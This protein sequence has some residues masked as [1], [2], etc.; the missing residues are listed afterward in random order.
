MPIINPKGT[1]TTGVVSTTTSNSSANHTHVVGDIAGLVTLLLNKS[2]KTHLHNIGDITGLTMALSSK[3]DTAFVASKANI[4]HVHTLSEITELMTELAKKSSV[5]HIHDMTQITGLQASLQNLAPAVHSHGI[6]DIAGLSTQLSTINTQITSI[7]ATLTTMASSITKATADIQTLQTTTAQHSTQIATLVSQV[8]SLLTANIA[9]PVNVAIPVVSGNNTVG[10]QLTTSNGTWT[11]TPTSYLYQWYRRLSSGVA[12]QIVGATAYSY[13]LTSDDAGMLMSVSVTAA[14]AVGNGFATSI[15]TTAI[16]MGPTNSILPTIS[17]TNIVGGTLSISTGTWSGMPTYTYQWYRGSSMISGETG[18]T[19]IASAA[20]IGASI[21]ATVTAAIATGSTTLQ[22]APVIIYSIPTNSVEPSISQ[23]TIDVNTLVTVN[24]GTWTGSP[25]FSYQWKRN[26]VDI[27]NATAAS[28]TTVIADSNTSLSCVITGTNI[29]GVLVKTTN[30]V[31]VGTTTSLGTLYGT[32]ERANLGLNAN[33]NDCLLFPAD[34]AF[35]IKCIGLPP[36]LYNPV[37]MG[38]FGDTVITPDFGSYTAITTDEPSTMYGIPY[39]V[40]DGNS[41]AWSSITWDTNP[42]Y[43]FSSQ[44]DAGPMPIP[45]DALVEGGITGVDRHVIVIDKPNKKLYELYRASKTANSWMVSSA[46][47]FD[48]T[49]NNWRPSASAGWMSA[50]SSGMPI[51]P[52]LVRYEE[53]SL[54]AGGIKHAIRFTLPITRAAYTAPASNFDSYYDQMIYPP[55]GAKFRLKSSFIIPSTYSAET[56]A[57]LTAMKEYGI[58]LADSGEAG[59]ISGTGDSRWN[60]ALLT[61]ELSAVTLNDFEIID[62]GSMTTAEGVATSSAPTIVTQP[63]ILSVPAFDTQTYSSAGEWRWDITRFDYQWY[64]NGV[65]IAEATSSAYT[66]ILSDVGKDLTMRV[67]AYNLFGSTTA[68]TEPVT[69]LAAAPIVELNLPPIRPNTYTDVQSVSNPVVGALTGVRTFDIGPGKTYTTPDTFPWDSLLAGDVVNIHY[70]ATPYNSIIT[71]DAIGTEAQ[72][73]IINGV[74]DSNGNRPV[75]DVTTLGVTASASAEVYYPASTRSPSAGWQ[76]LGVINVLPRYSRQFSGNGSTYYAQHIKIKNIEIKGAYTLTPNA[77]KASDG[78]Y[79]K[80]LNGAGIYLRGTKNITIENCVIYDNAFGIFTFTGSSAIAATNIYTVIR[81]NRVYNNGVVGSYTEHN[82]YVQG[83]SPV[84]EGNYIGAVRAGSPGSSYKSRASGEVF[85]YNWVEA[86]ARAVDFVHAE[87]SFTSIVAQNDRKFTYCYGNVICNTAAAGAYTW[88]PLHFGGDNSGEDSTSD[89]SFKIAS[90]LG[91]GTTPTRYREQLFFWNNTYISNGTGAPYDNSKYFDL[92]LS[93]GNASRDGYI[94]Q[95]TRVDAWNNVFYTNSG[96]QSWVEYAGTCSLVGTNASFGIVNDR[97][98]HTAPYIDGRVTL[99]KKGTIE[100]ANPE[101]TNLAALDLRP[102]VTSPVRNVGSDFPIATVPAGIQPYVV[103]YMPRTRTNG[104]IPRTIQ[105]SSIDLGAFEYIDNSAPVCSANPRIAGTTTIVGSVINCTT[106]V[107]TNSPTFTYQWYRNSVLINGATNSSYSA[108]ASDDKMVLVCKVTATSGANTAYIYSNNLYIGAEVP[109]VNETW[110]WGAPGG[111]GGTGDGTTAIAPSKII[112]PTII[113]N[114]Y[115]GSTV[116]ALE[117]GWVNGVVSFA[118]SWKRSDVAIAGATTKK[119][120]LTTD[121]IGSILTVTITATNSTGNNSATSAAFTVI[122]TQTGNYE[123]KNGFFDFSKANGTTATDYGFGSLSGGA[124][125]YI[126]DNSSLRN[127]NGTGTYG[128]N[129]TSLVTGK[130]YTRFDIITKLP[131]YAGSIIAWLSPLTNTSADNISMRVDTTVST[132]SGYS[133]SAFQN[134]GT[135][136]SY[137]VDQISI[138][139]V[140]HNNMV[141][142]INNGRIVVS[143]TKTHTVPNTGF[144]LVL[145]APAGQETLGAIDC[146]NVV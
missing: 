86:S 114:D 43:N 132:I 144:G 116:I 75:F 121:D 77:V 146:M 54:G 61:T 36:S 139:L 107:W 133:E 38:V 120:V 136:S 74:T 34:N 56:K 104:M 85:R 12:S 70:S 93:G 39:Y 112:D 82:M 22:S 80:W 58:I 62:W 60:K 10:S 3:A 57:I 92:S 119:Y 78:T 68:I 94:H 125:T 30:S 124:H 103:E 63:E 37:I 91:Y 27:T 90:P 127:T 23:T 52:G 100:T 29:A 110:G 19:Y 35:N 53:A 76:R 123:P 84:V 67:I 48:I 9:A 50:D 31:L 49:T 101:F 89:L 64:A 11:N 51:F 83:I 44:S 69:V 16:T 42:D 59:A 71:M 25:L 7:G 111:T 145:T 17:G 21:T 5:S 96:E 33:L 138:S 88:S 1:S 87:E 99:L 131:N 118:Y 126:T 98:T 73:V 13:T 81:N 141:Y 122:A 24:V 32:V 26:G 137:G 47:K 105:G 20:D 2:E 143:F 46:A 130:L 142:V 117:G 109:I 108:T 18:A 97:T 128:H 129:I 6:T 140:E 113:G 134:K 66:P 8:N 4:S 115:V 55:L 65:A 72:P 102:T 28:Y 40:I 41:A 106:G 135:F 79:W 15:E 95:R 45:N 14:N